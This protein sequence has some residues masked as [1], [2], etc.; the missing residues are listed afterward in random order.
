MQESILYHVCNQY[1]DYKVNAIISY[2][3]EEQV[4]SYT[5]AGFE[6]EDDLTFLEASLP[7]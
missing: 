5:R 2:Y 4:A 7:L 1:L 6:I 3:D